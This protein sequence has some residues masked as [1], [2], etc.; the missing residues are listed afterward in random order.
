MNEGTPAG[1]YDAAFTAFQRYSTYDFRDLTVRTSTGT[2]QPGRLYA[3]LWSFSAGAANGRFASTFALF[4]LIPDPS[5]ASRYYV[6]KF[7]LAGINPQ[8]FF[9][10]ITNSRG[11]TASATDFTVSRRSRTVASGFTDFPEYEN[12]VQNPDPAIWLSAATPTFSVQSVAPFCGST[13]S[14]QMA[15]TTTSTVA[16]QLIITID[17][18]GTAGYQAGGRDVVVEKAVAA[19]TTTVVWNGL[20][21]LG[22]PAPS[23][24]AVPLGFKSGAAPVNFP[25][26]DAEN[27]VGGFRIEDVRPG[28]GFDVLFW[29]DS[30]L[31]ATAFPAPQANLSGVLSSGGV[32]D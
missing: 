17:L 3:K 22:T 30:N 1:A 25:V 10:F 19:G 15:F 24:T 21:G 16:G 7:E 4:P 2:E 18:D 11:T 32:H 31:S 28:T 8:N 9:R 27:N 6:K 26:V 13:G 12:F 5:T 23:G 14:G 20:D 29:N